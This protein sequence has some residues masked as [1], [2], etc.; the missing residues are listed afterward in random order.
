ML[1]CALPGAGLHYQALVEAAALTAETP[2]LL[3]LEDM[4][5]SD[6]ASV[7][8]LRHLAERAHGQ[9]LL[10]VVTARPEDIERNNPTLKKCYTEMHARGICEELA[11][12]VLKVN[13]IA[14][15]LEAALEEGNP[16]LVAAALGDIARSKGM[17]AVAR[18]AG[19]GRES[20]Y[21]ALSAKGNPEL[22]TV[23]RVVRAVGLKLH[24]VL[25]R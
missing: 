12:Q 23:L 1:R 9:R 25:A 16:A 14:A 8:M 4:H 20:L 10:L 19:L 13:D 24:A 15:Y 2:V 7:D 5:W 22:S 21:K 3:L 17:A 18:K 6:P 11:L